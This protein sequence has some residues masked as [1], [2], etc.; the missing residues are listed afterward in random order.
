M[1]DEFE[2]RERTAVDHVADIVVAYLS[3]NHAAP[4]D[5]PALIA[6][7]HAA[8][9]GLAEG[10]PA[11]AAKPK[12]TDSQVRKSIRPDA[13]ISFIDGKPYKALRRHLTRHGI[14]P[15]I[16]RQRYGLP[17]DYPMVAASYSARRSEISR[18]ISFGR[19][20]RR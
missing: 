5:L 17:V 13:L 8:L 12:A 6:C 9:A 16:Y 19:H 15:Q 10:L 1:T 11:P 20:V 7:V 18:G 14:D 2:G 3:N 4:G